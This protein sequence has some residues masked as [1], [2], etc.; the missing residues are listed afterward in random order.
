VLIEGRTIIMNYGVVL[1]DE[2]DVHLHISWQQRIGYWLKQHFPN[3]QFIV[4]TH[5]PFICQAAD[6]RGI[7]RLP[8]PGEGGRAMHVE[9]EQFRRIVNGSADDAAMSVLFGLDSTY[10][11]TARRLR[12][13]YSRLRARQIRGTFTEKERKRLDEL[14]MELPLGPKQEIETL[15]ETLEALEPQ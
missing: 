12:T 5:S 3:V 1:V 2:I 6:S 8:A 10:S 9:G 15:A 13:E 11:P 4:S 14:Q 7:I